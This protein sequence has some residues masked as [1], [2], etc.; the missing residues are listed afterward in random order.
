MPNRRLFHCVILSFLILAV[1]AIWFFSGCAPLDPSI[2]RLL[3][4]DTVLINGNVITVDQDDRIVEAVAIKDGKILAVGKSTD[5]RQ[6]A[7]NTARIIDLAGAT[8]TPGLMDSHCHFSGTHMLY[9]LDLAYPAVESIEDILQKIKKQ[10]ETLK[11]GDWIRGGGWDEGKLKELRYIYAADLDRVSPDNP[12]FI[13]HTMGH[14]GT[15]NSYALKLAGITEATKDP[16]A[17]TID[18]DENGQPTGVLKEAAQ[19]L[20]T[21]LIPGLSDEQEREGLLKMIQGFHKEGMTGLKDPGISAKQW[22]HYQ[23][24][25]DQGKLNVRVFALWWAPKTVDGAESLIDRIGSFTKPYITT[26]DDLLISGGVKCLIDGS[27]G[28]RTAW[29]YSDWN[30]NYTDKDKGNVGYSVIDPEIYRKQVEMFHKA[31]LHVG[32]HAIGD[33]AIDW[34]MDTYKK[35]ID[36]TPIK[37]LRHA[38]IHCNIPT[39]RAI[40]MMADMQSIYDAGYPEAQSPFTWWIGDT[41]AGNFGPERSLRLMPF[42]SYLDNGIVWGGGSDFAV[43]PFPARYGIW[44]SIARKPLK[45]SYGLNPFGD[46]QSVDVRAALRSYTIWNAYLMFM[47]D[48]IGSI[49]VGKYADLAVWDKDMYSIETDEIKDLKCLMT[50]FAG[51]IVHEAEESPIHVTEPNRN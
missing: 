34:V 35:A 46:E 19:S 40:Q 29:L 30:K 33:R 20:V 9:A 12:V 49:E 27:G 14:Y 25:L 8:V 48:K 32:T 10:V 31:G 7:G 4:P 22:R 39:D 1:T 36:E 44:A 16:D 17:G 50:L 26:G 18:R 42:K 43:T 2:A 41:Y 3:N 45:G 51:E 11:P 6:L 47:E 37:G 5:I 23:Y 24:L 13:S 15:C 38:I 28:A 21:R